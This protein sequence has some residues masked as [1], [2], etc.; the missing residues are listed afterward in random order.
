MKGL[1]TAE[2]QARMEA[3]M[4]KKGNLTFSSATFTSISGK[5]QT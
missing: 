3:R 4:C 2:A 5:K 1:M